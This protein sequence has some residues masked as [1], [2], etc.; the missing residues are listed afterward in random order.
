MANEVGKL[1][2]NDVAPVADIDQAVQLGGG[3]PDGPAKIA[4]KTGLETLIDTLEE[5][6]EETGADRY[7]VADGLREA[8]ESGGFYGSDDDAPA[9]F[10]NVTVEYPG[11]MV[12][13]IELD[14]PH[15]MNTVSPDLMDDLADAVDLLEN[16]DEVRAI[17]LTGAGDKAFS[18]GADVQAMA[19]NATPLDAIELS[20]KG[21]QT[22]G[23]LEELD[24]GRRRHRR[25]LS[26]RRDGTRNVCRPP[27][28]H[29]ALRTRPARAR[30]RPPAGL[31]R[32]APPP[33]IVGDGRAKEIIFSADRYDAD[34]MAEYGFVNEVV[35][36][37]ALHER[38]LEMA[39]DRPPARRSHSAHQARH[40]R[41]P[42]RHRRWPRSRIT[43]L[44][45][46]HRDR[47]RD[48][49]R[50]RVHGRRRAGLR[51]EVI[52]DSRPPSKY[53][54]AVCGDVSGMVC[55]REPHACGYAPH[56]ASPMGLK[57]SNGT[58]AVR[59]VGVV[60]PIILAFRAEDQGSNP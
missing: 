13:H 56:L 34:E 21:Q 30:P 16:D 38:A 11:D 53:V 59:S 48:G 5:T 32:H 36:N 26:R 39:E 24:A 18:A 17:L 46:P 35:D 42:R 22:F 33:R 47:R 55:L 49:G 50:R 57:W 41:R 14:R 54:P 60:R 23:K 19:S 28:R 1:V 2:E 37:D 8:A 40:A 9:E 58:I 43:G 20:R 25:L 45:P 4:D 51:R 6:H 10:D 44:R 15:R 29:G 31:G 7:A 3:F 52:A 12:G 27:H